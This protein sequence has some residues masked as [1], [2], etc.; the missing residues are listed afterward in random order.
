MT[1]ENKDYFQ[2]KRRTYFLLDFMKNSNIY[3]FLDR[4]VDMKQL[5]PTSVIFRIYKRYEPNSFT[6]EWFKIKLGTLATP[7]PSYVKYLR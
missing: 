7:S 3:G 1:F 5:S 2:K 4:K 6:N